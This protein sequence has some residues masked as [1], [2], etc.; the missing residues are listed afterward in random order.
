MRNSQKQSFLMDLDCP[1]SQNTPINDASKNL[2]S[3]WLEPRIG[4]TTVFFRKK[5][6]IV[7]NYADE[8][9]EVAA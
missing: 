5:L 7:T 4:V 6:K 1:Y 9:G 3:D 8:T 2:Q